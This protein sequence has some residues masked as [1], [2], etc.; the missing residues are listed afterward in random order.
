MTE[1]DEI[2]ESIWN[3][4]SI[5]V[6][7]G[8]NTFFPIRSH[9]DAEIVARSYCPDQGETVIANVAEALWQRARATRVALDELRK[10][11]ADHL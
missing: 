10:L 7:N 1:A 8:L 5:L 3:S 11:D 6:G 9:G 2:A 4:R